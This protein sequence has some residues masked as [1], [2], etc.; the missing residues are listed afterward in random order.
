MSELGWTI[1]LIGGMLLL[2]ASGM[3]IAFSLLLP[4]LV[5]VF[6][7]MGLKGFGALSATA[8]ILATSYWLIAIPLFIF[9]AAIFDEAGLAG[10]IYQSLTVL[11]SGVPGSLAAGTTA[12]CA[13]FSAISG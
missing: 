3:P 7:I 4:A 10:D 12:A 2:L 8:W 13:F 5:V 1:I 9:L 6:G 11:T